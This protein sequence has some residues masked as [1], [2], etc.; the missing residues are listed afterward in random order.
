MVIS[1]ISIPRIVVRVAVIFPDNMLTL[2]FPR[3]RE[4][5]DMD[6]TGSP[7]KALGDDIITNSFFSLT[8]QMISITSTD[9]AKQNNGSRV[10]L[11]AL[12]LLALIS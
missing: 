5:P 8:I 9:H 4:S 6:N 12:P 7:I 1:Q 11:S 2:S 3:R 10:V